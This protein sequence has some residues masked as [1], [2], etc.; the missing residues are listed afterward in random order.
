MLSADYAFIMTITGKWWSKM[1][2]NFANY[3]ANRFL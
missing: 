1:A 3:L 2:I